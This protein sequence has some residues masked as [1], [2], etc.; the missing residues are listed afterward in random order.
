MTK[1]ERDTLIRL[2]SS[3]PRG[4]KLAAAKE[5]GADLTLLVSSL[6]LTPSERL[7]RLS[8]AQAFVLELQTSRKSEGTKQNAASA[9]PGPK[10]KFEIILK[11]V[12]DTQVPFVMV[13]DLAAAAYGLVPRTSLL[14]V[15]YDRGRDNIERLA[16]ALEP[17]HPRLRDIANHLPFRLDSATIANGMNFTLSTDLGDIDLLGEVAGIGGYKVAKTLSVNLV[18]FGL[19]CSVLSLDGLI[20]SKRA[21]GRAKDLLTLPEI[22]ALREIGAQ[23]KLEPRLAETQNHDGAPGKRSDKGTTD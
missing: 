8:D 10:N 5:F 23:V 9:E 7:E 13:G 19:D 15:C 21:T 4:S 18:L 3:P 12:R 22:E 17:F 20:Q 11:A 16:R 6:E 14:E 2:I 1:K